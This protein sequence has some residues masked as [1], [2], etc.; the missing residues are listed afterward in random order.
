MVKAEFVTVT[1]NDISSFGINWSLQK[2]NFVS[3]I[4]TGYQTNNT[5]FVQY[6]TGNVTNQ[7]SWVLTTGRGKLVAAPMATTLNNLPVIFQNIQQVPVFLSQP[8]ISQNGTVALAPQLTIFQ[9]S[10]GLTILPRLNADDTI[11]LLGSVFVT[12]LGPLVTGPNGETAPT[13]L[14]Q[15]APVQ[16]IIRNGDTMVV[17]GLTSK[18]TAVSSNKVPL[19]GDMPIIGTL[20]RSR[21]TTVRDSDLLV[22]I[23]AS[24]IPERSSNT[25]LTGP[26]ANNLTA[27]GGS[28]GLNP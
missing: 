19:L 20:F 28:G 16:R 12:D 1:Q 4:N 26:G 13:L 24:I 17:G 3:G 27:P 11:T 10:T 2:A 15:Q 7:M 25:T 8:I 18:N 5:A 9:A 21:N 22:F 23:T 14:I 6:A